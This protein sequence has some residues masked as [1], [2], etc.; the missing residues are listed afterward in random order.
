[1]AP[2]RNITNIATV[3]W[4]AFSEQIRVIINTNNVVPHQQGLEDMANQIERLRARLEFS[5]DDVST[6]HKSTNGE[7]KT[8]RSN[9]RNNRRRNR[10]QL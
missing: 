6:L 2:K 3:H 7:T 9:R 8:F 10:S 4:T 1:M 5:Q